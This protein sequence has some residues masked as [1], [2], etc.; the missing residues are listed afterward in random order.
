[1]MLELLA[2]TVLVGLA[3]L[4]IDS[5]RAREAAVDA[6]RRACSGD[7]VQFLDDTVMLEAIRFARDAG[8]RL[9]LRRVYCFEF[10]DTGNNRLMGSVTLA[11]SS[12]DTL[13]LAPHRANDP[14]PRNLDL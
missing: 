7:G 2:L 4:G 12:V 5:L 13:H 1:M 6:A 9:M 11:G 14:V 10:S 8:G 3:W